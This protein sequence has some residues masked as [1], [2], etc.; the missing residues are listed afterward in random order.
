MKTTTFLKPSLAAVK[1]LMALFMCAVFFSGCDRIK[2]HLDDIGDDVEDNK[3]KTFE[4]YL[5][6]LNN[7]GVTGKATIQYSKDGMFKVLVEARGLAA[8]RNHPQHIHGFMPDGDMPNKN[9]VCPPPGAAGAD[10]LI[11]LVDGLPFYGPVLIPLDDQL[12][13]LTSGDFPYI[14]FDHKLYYYEEVATELLIQAFDNAYNGQQTEADLMLINRVIVL[15]GA[16]VKD[17]KIV[18]NWTQGVE[19]IPTLPVACGEIM[20]K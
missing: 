18:K 11:D 14:G 20:K 16:F 10:G 13:P 12:V 6:P 5:A 2:D 7:S 1:P 8:D 3:M 4:A 15:H 17:G 19:Y 9:A